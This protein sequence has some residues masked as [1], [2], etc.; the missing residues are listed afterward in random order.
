MSI[1]FVAAIALLAMAGA[2]QAK[3]AVTS[4]K[5]VQTRSGYGAPYVAGSRGVAN[6]LVVL[7]ESGGVA[8]MDRQTVLRLMGRVVKAGEVGKARV[9]RDVQVPGPVMRGV[10]KAVRDSGFMRL[11]S[12]YAGRPIADGMTR[13]VRVTML[14]K[15]KAVSVAD[16]AEVPAA[17]ET[18]W[19]AANDAMTARGSIVK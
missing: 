9:N 6:S 4:R 16:G 19:K 10:E 8:G 15:T 7:R 12:R 11:S 14:G 3:D 17:F 18:V 1:R 2:A 5:T 13:T